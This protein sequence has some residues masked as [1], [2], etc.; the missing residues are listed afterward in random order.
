M[1]AATTELENAKASLLK[2][3]FREQWDYAALASHLER[4]A[5]IF[6]RTSRDQH[7]AMTSEFHNLAGRFR[8]FRTGT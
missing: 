4:F 7:G 2:E 6:M 8:I 1:L 3:P 5:G